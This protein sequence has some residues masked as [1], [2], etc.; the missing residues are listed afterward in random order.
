MKK[1]LLR[2]V[3]R[4]EVVGLARIT[5][6][7]LAVFLFLLEFGFRSDGS[8]AQLLDQLSYG[9]V[10]AAAFVTLG[11][12]LR[13]SFREQHVRKAELIWLFAALLLI[14][15]KPAGMAVWHHAYHWPNLVFLLGFIFI[16]LS[17]LELGRNSTLFNPA[18]LFTTSFVLIIAVGTALYLL[19]KAGTRQITLIE[20]L[21][22]ST[23]AVC[24]TG[25]SV[26]D[27]SKD[28]TF[29]GQC[30]LLFLIQIGGLGVMTFT[31]FFAFFFK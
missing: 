25:L 28:L 4:K 29:A 23:S 24:V 13:T 1:T 10:I 12:L 6:I 26:I 22:T 21:F 2:T 5:V 31:S 3:L 20:A 18:L 8:T 14:F 27:V 17:R 15:I 7:I 11:S 9:L 19:P 30:V 16:E